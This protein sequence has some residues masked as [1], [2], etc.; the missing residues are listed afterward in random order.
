MD[1]YAK[2]F[3]TAA[4]ALPTNVLVRVLKERFEGGNSINGEDYC[5]DLAAMF[6]EAAEIQADR[7]RNYKPP[8]PG[9]LPIYGA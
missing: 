9:S 8:A 4:E 2:R 6:H 3:F 1:A 7:K 5:R